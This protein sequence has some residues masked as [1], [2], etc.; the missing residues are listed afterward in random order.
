LVTSLP[1][2]NKQ[3]NKQTNSLLLKKIL[4]PNIKNCKNGEIL[5]GKNTFQT[6]KRISFFL[7]FSKNNE[8]SPLKTMRAQ[9]QG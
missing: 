2:T 8:N 5:L 1:K 4:P 6:E 9:R 7:K 3:T